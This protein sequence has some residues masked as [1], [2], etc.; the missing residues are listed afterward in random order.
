MFE[1]KPPFNPS[2]V[3]AEIAQLTKEYRCSSIVGDNYGANWTSEAFT[4]AGVTYVKSELDRSKVYT[5]CLPLFT[6]GRVRLL[7]HAKTVS[8]FAALERRSFSTGRERIDPGPGHDDCANSAA[9]ALS[10]AAR[11][12]VINAELLAKV[13]C[14]RPPLL[15]PGQKFG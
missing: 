6:A 10:F 2:E 12:S 5:D 9:I 14:D 3:V 7:D 4:K 15:K 1:R 8:E 13:M 11:G